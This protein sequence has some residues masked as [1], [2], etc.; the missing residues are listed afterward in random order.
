M[1]PGT[2]KSVLR[3]SG[4]YQMRGSTVTS[5][6]RGDRAGRQLDAPTAAR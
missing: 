5:G 4:L 2:R 6:A 3:S 1:R